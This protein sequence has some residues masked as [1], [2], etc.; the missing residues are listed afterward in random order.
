MPRDMRATRYRQAEA[1]RGFLNRHDFVDYAREYFDDIL[2]TVSDLNDGRHAPDRMSLG[3]LGY[4]LSIA[5]GSVGTTSAAGNFSN[6]EPGAKLSFGTASTYTV[7]KVSGATLHFSVNVASNQYA[8]TNGSSWWVT[9]PT[10]DLKARVMGDA[11]SALAYTA[12]IASA[13]SAGDV[14]AKMN[15][16]MAELSALIKP[17]YS[18]LLEMKA[19]DLAWGIKRANV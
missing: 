2:S 17:L 18:A 13:T 6:I 7:W 8:S 3:Q 1:D 9:N 16:A 10:K 14:V 5:A 15:S 4:T 12:I 11:L 19:D